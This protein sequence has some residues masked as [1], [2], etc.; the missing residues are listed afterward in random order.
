[1]RLSQRANSYRTPYMQP[2]TYGKAISATAL[3]IL[4]ASCAAF[5]KGYGGA[6][7]EGR[8]ID[9]RTKQPLEGVIVVQYWELRRPTVVGHSNFAGVLHVDETVTDKD[10][11]Y[12]FGRWG[13][14]TVPAGGVIVYSGSPDLSF[15]K[16]GYIPAGR[17]NYL[18]EAYGAHERSSAMWSDWRGKTI[19]LEPASNSLKDYARRLVSQDISFSAMYG[20]SCDWLKIPRMVSAL[21]KEKMRLSQAGVSSSITDIDQLA[22]KGNCGNVREILREYLR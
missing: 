7:L 3:A 21:H 18:P 8:V 17:G 19:E 2:L 10:G 12:T 14:V 22:E 16:P 20:G 15:F 5:P 4:L 11:R 6:P 13:P 1:M 9:A